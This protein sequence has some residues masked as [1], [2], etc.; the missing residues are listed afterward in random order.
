VGHLFKQSWKG[1]V[2]S[3]WQNS[4][5]L[6]IYLNADRRSCEEILR[7]CERD[8]WDV[9][10]ALRWAREQGHPIRRKLKRYPP[11]NLKRFLWIDENWR[12]IP[13]AWWRKLATSS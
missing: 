1:D 6:G 9:Q 5:I 8:G 2:A 11:L 10:K 13:P 12:W 3:D 4:R 7:I